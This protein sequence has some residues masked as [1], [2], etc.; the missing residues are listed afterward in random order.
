MPSPTAALTTLRPDLAASFEEFDLA[1]DRQGFIADQVFPFMDVASASGQFGIIPI[2]Q[3]LQNR[4]TA[5]APGSGYNRGQFRFEKGTYATTEDGAEEVV[6]DNEA[7]MYA[8]YFDAEMI[9]ANRA[10]DAVLRN[11][12][13]R[14][15]DLLFNATTFSGQT[16]AVS[17]DWTTHA[18]A[19]PIANVET[20]VQAV[21]ARCG[22]WPNTLILG[23]QAFRHLRQCTEI[24]NGIQGAGAGER[25]LPRDVLIDHLR[26][27]FDL[28]KI[29]V[30]GSTKT[31]NNEGAA[32]AISQIWNGDLALV[33]VTATDN[34][35]RRPCLGRTFHWGGDGS[36]P[37]GMAES[38]RD[39]TVR[40]DVI[41]V[42]Q[43]VDEKIL[44]L[45]CGQLLTGVLT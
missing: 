30:G 41:R 9:A 16:T 3:L 20:A 27:A 31:T 26:A 1:A 34:D 40:G 38:Y 43:Q 15:A 7:R 33:T 11:R 17:V 28:D 37:G 32:T 8:N 21:Y 10:R 4:D 42:R 13:K 2:E 23:Y 5:R 22:L 14:I 18:T 39:E 29:I 36:V 35:I 12:E 44:Y 19:V 25:A 45:T 6:D 24:I